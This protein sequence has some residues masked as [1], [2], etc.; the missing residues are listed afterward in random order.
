MQKWRL[1]AQRPRGA[2]RPMSTYRANKINKINNNNWKTKLDKGQKV[3][4]GMVR[5]G[6]GKYKQLLCQRV[7]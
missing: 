7:G 1:R 6:D 5:G 2:D 3:W 4:Y